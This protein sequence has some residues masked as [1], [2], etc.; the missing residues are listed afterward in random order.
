M[1]MHT[2]DDER[3]RA[4][5]RAVI[6]ALVALLIMGIPAAIWMWAS[7]SSAS[8]S[9]AEILDNNRLG[10]AT[11]DIEL[12]STDAVFDARNLAPGDQVSGHVEVTNVGTLPLVLSFSAVSSAG[13]LADWLRFSVWT[14]P[15]S[16]RADDITAGRASVLAQD[17][18]IDATGTGSLTSAD[19]PMRL[20]TDETIVLCL[21]A[22]LPL[23]AGNDIQ[24]QTLT[25]NLIVDAVHDLE[26]DE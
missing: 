13:P 7:Q 26:V 25:V 22:R 3:R 1:N 15:D 2:D 24:G 23:E 10:A 6:A 18:A 9:D 11:L 21:G 16:C 8:F 5:L 20:S 4:D 14:V 17:F 12:G 19:G